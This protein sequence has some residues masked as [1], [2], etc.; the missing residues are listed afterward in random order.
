MV[1]L[2]TTYLNKW[3]RPTDKTYGP[4]FY[5]TQASPT[6]YNGRLIF[7]VNESRFD[8]VKDTGSGLVCVAQMAGINGAKRW[9]DR[10][11]KY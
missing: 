11:P 6:K 7:K 4:E 10:Q 8:V 5:D 3:H 1:V 9:I 2:M